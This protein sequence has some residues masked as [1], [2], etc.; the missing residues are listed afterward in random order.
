MVGWTRIAV[1]L[2]RR[3]LAVRTILVKTSIQEWRGHMLDDQPLG[4]LYWIDHYVVGS[5]DLDRWGDF[6]TKLL[7]AQPHGDVGPAGRRFILFQDLT[8]C[9][10]HG[11]MLS[12]EPLPPSAGLGKGL[13]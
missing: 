4:T 13:P 2:G 9:C 12:P 11:A 3:A 5:D 6:Q 10:H 7:G 8:P 1:G